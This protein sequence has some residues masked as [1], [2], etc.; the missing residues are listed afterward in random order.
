M[1]MADLQN[2]A[3]PY[4]TALF[5]SCINNLIA[6]KIMDHFKILNSILYR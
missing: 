1:K 6:D 2:L 5:A 3:S 4:K